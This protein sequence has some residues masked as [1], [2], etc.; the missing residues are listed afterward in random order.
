M[1]YDLFCLFIEFLESVSTTIGIFNDDNI[2]FSAIDMLDI[3]CN[4]MVYH[5]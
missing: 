3:D 4:D 1:F 5:M 2:V